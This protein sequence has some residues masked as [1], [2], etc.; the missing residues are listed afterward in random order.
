[1]NNI[2]NP[3]PCCIK[4]LKKI[5]QYNIIRNV[6]NRIQFFLPNYPITFSSY[7]NRSVL[8]YTIGVNTRI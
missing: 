4:L 1:M 3:F 5:F 8:I 7:E 6:E 2:I